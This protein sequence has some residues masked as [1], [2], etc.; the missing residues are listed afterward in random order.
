MSYVP[1]MVHS[2]TWN[3]YWKIWEMALQI[4]RS[5]AKWFS[6]SKFIIVWDSW[7]SLSIIIVF[8]IAYLWNKDLQN[9]NNW[10]ISWNIPVASLWHKWKMKHDFSSNRL[11]RD[12]TLYLHYCN[13]HPYMSWPTNYWWLSKTY[14]ALISLNYKLLVKTYSDDIDNAIQWLEESLYPIVNVFW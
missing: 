3:E 12:R 8:N 2:S 9:E 5:W 7:I 6:K 1:I 11:A 10:I 4:I 13:L 14:F